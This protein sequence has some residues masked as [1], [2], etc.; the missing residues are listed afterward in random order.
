MPEHA[1]L[2]LVVENDSRMSSL[3]RR[4]LEAE[5]FRVETAGDGESAAEKAAQLGPDLVITEILLSGMDGLSLCR[6]LKDDPRTGK[7]PIL[8][9]SELMVR[10]RS[11][12]AGADAFLLKPMD[13]AQFVMTVKELT[14]RSRDLHASSWQRLATGD[15]N[16]D[17]VLG[18]GLPV[19]AIHLIAGA[20]GTGKSVLAQ[21]ILFSNAS[22]E[23]PAA[24]VTAPWEGLEKAVRYVQRFSF[25]D[26]DKMTRNVKFLDV[27]DRLVREGISC[28]PEI[29]MDIVRSN[30]PKII[31]ID[32]FRSLRTFS[33]SMVEYRKTLF[34]IV[35][36]FS[37]YSLT[38]LWVGEYSET[39]I[40]VV[41]EAA[42][43]DG[44]IWLE[45]RNIGDEDL[46]LLRI[47]KLRGSNYLPGEHRLEITQDGIRLN[48]LVN[49]P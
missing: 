2:I 19:N 28:L 26:P 18:G 33:P 1:P 8:V 32:S 4:I 14:Q 43:A 21:Q 23:F 42:A 3:E 48:P 47:Q 44:I 25:F 13:E 15:K 37:A 41:P 40:D 29:I 22:D 46:R 38:A 35:R 34:G 11:R 39:A 5:G 27:S 6:R 9:F 7:I 31:A 12:E 49:M 30:F 36:L 17:A 45:N 24:Y 20:F 10:Q 16:L